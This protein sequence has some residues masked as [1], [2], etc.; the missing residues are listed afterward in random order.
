LLWLGVVLLVA[1][2]AAVLPLPYP[3]AV[4]DLAH[5]AQPPMGPGHHW[6]GTDTQGR[7][8]LSILVFGARTAVLITVPAAV[9]SAVLGALAGGAAGFWGNALRL[10]VPYWLLTFGGGWWALQLPGPALGLAAGALGLAALCLIRGGKRRL[11]TWALPIDSVVMG[12]ATLLDTIPRLVLVVSIAAGA[13][14]SMGGL[15][16]LLALTAWPHPARL[17]RAQTLS[18]RALPFVEAARAAGIP[19]AQVWLRHAL[20]HAIQ[21]LRTSF[22]LSIASLLGLESTLSFLG[23]GLPPD[24]ASWGHLL[25]TVRSEP[26]AWWAFIF[27]SICLLFTI[28]SLSIIAQARSHVMKTS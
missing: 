28:L 19:A 23:I 7:D 14:V 12:A 24:A 13:Q 11:P 26:T 9:L 10:P 1:A 8:V 22:P 4:P 6:L 17:V 15:L 2:L 21:P 18:V 16:A 25:A 3:P 20:P 27:P 5:V